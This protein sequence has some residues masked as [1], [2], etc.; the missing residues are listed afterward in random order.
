[1]AKT[2]ANLLFSKRSFCVKE[3]EGFFEIFQKFSFLN[4]IFNFKFLKSISNK[5]WIAKTITGDT[6]REGQRI[7]KRRTTCKKRTN[8]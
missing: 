4:G 6:K 5:R 8:K 3:N 1:M 2:L 7:A